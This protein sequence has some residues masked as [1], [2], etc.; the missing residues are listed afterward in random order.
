M[1]AAL[2][3]SILRF[4]SVVSRSMY[5][6]ELD[7]KE[8]LIAAFPDVDAARSATAGILPRMY[9]DESIF[10]DGAYVPEMADSAPPPGVRDRNFP[11]VGASATPAAG[12]EPIGRDAARAGTIPHT[13]VAVGGPK[14]KRPTKKKEASN[15]ADVADSSAAQAAAAKLPKRRT[16]KT[17]PPP[18]HPPVATLENVNLDID[19]PPTAHDDLAYM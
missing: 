19:S 12:G 7:M 17:A 13:I 5:E 16:K 9:A 1:D 10:G 14:R 18:P 4:L 8:R 2:H 15:P 6:A 11:V 3:S